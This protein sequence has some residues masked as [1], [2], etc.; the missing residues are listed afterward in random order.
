MAPDNNKNNIQSF[1]SRQLIVNCHK[2]AHVEP[3]KN[4]T[5]FSMGLK[6]E[7]QI[8]ITTKQMSKLLLHIL[9]NDLLG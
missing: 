8:W 5:V 7:R 9:E 2:G 4:N 1:Q 6:S 3:N